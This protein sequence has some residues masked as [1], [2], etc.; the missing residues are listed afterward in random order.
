M[1][2]LCPPPLRSGLALVLVTHAHALSLL[3]A[4]QGDMMHALDSSTESGPP[5][6]N[7]DSLTMA[8]GNHGR[9]FLIWE[10]G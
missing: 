8:W 9:H 4:V 2:S 7:A 5:V 3:A 10:M 1:T 6:L